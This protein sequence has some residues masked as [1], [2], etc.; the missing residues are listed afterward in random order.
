[1]VGP[2]DEQLVVLGRVVDALGS[3]GIDYM[4]SGSIAASYYA[5][6]RMT[7]DV[8]IVLDLRLEHVS[9]L[10]AA[11]ADDFYCDAG[12][13]ARAAETRQLVNAIHLESLLKIDFIV[14]KDDAY[15]REEFDRRVERQL[16]ERRF[17]LVSPEDLVLAKLLWMQQSGSA[18]QRL[19][20][21]N[22]LQ[23]VSELD[24]DYLMLW[25]PLLGVSTL[26]DEVK[27]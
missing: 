4:V 12:A 6:P 10:A 9:A 8:D 25:A 3:V 26:L 23:S 17:H 19:D 18:V 2:G 13:L 21:Q 16:G 24:W 5:R 20:V 11:L 22:L 7:R 14:R 15:H 1:M 27:S